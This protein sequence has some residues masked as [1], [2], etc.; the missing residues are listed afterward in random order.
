MKHAATV[1][2]KL[3]LIHD[4][5]KVIENERKEATVDQH[6][7][8]RLT[9][10]ERIAGLLDLNSF[11]ELDQWHRPYETGFDIGEETG[12]GDGVVVGYGTVDKRSIT[13][14]AQDATVMGGTVGTVHARKICMII[15]NALNAKTPIIG[16]FDSE[17]IRAQDVIQYPDF[18]S[19]GAIARFHT[20]CS[21]VIPKIALIMGPCT[22]DLSLIAGLSDFVFMVK[23]SSF[24][25]LMPLSGNKTHEAAGDAW[26]V[27][28]KLTGSCDVIA[29]NDQDCIL[30]CKQLLS[31]LPLNNSQ[32]PPVIDMGDD[33][34]RKEEE[35]LELVPVD[36]SRPYS[37]YKLI[38]LI[39]DKGEFFEL[40]RFWAK[41]LI[42]GFAR[43]H[44][45]SVG[46]IANN[47][48]DKGGCMTLDAADKMAHFVRLCDAF[49]IPCIWL[50]D[51]PAFLPSVEEET[52]GLIRHG[53]GMILANT[54][55]TVPKITVFVRKAYGGGRLSMPG[56]FLMGDLQVAWP[57]Y[58]PG[59]MGAEG[60]VAIIYRSEL[61]SI[62][63]EQER[64]KQK[65]KRVNEM[66]SGLDML[67]YESTQKFIDPRD[68]RPFL[69][70]ALKWLRNKQVVS[71]PKKHENIRL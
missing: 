14:W 48:E 44:G 68:T 29:E 65:Q 33:P 55:A 42:T 27:H 54:E 20:Q 17:G 28:S 58:E 6:K 2:A 35:L 69:I 5:E 60:A 52:R 61:Q 3:E 23:N 4:E 31:Y 71:F 62:K 64:E 70:R 45:N 47:P 43:L 59:L 40:R 53:S 12:W 56:Q 15:E 63:D 13:L 39:V 36:T 25:H 7:K 57:T 1:K 50:A 32:M 38:S 11:E 26:N 19:T 37:M 49:N 51:T 67:L 21:G 18:Y 46:I 10:H 34:D 16:I 22:G 24:M 8:N 9:A 30:K 41:N 66:Q